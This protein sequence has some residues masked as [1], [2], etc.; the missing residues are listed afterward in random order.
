MSSKKLSR[1]LLEGTGERVDLFAEEQMGLGGRLAW[2]RSATTLGGPTNWSTLVQVVLSF[3][4]SIAQKENV[5]S[6]PC[7][8]RAE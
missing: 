1:D 6:R 3:K 5:A 7:S 2:A 8:S 4:I